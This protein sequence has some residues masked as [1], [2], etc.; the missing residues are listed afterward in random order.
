[1]TEQD[2]LTTWN[3]QAKT[4]G[5]R[6]HRSLLPDAQYAIKQTLKEGWKIED[7]IGAIKNYAYVLSCEKFFFKYNQWTLCQ[8]LSRGKK[9]DKG[10]RWTWFHPEYFN[11]E[12]WYTKEVKQKLTQERERLAMIEKRRDMHPIKSPVKV[13]LAEEE[14]KPKREIWK[15][16]QALLKG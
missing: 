15:E 5:F 1:M 3:E 14:P 13:K 10:K 7:I 12:K 8:F 9:D 6:P 16:K 4:G 2:I 11:E